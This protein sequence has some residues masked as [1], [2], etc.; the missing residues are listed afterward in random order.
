MGAFHQVGKLKRKCQLTRKVKRISKPA[1]AN[2]S[3][4]SVSPLRQR[5]APPLNVSPTSSSKP[6]RTRT[7]RSRGPFVCQP[8]PCALRPVKHQMVRFQDLESLSNENSQA[9]D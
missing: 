4:K 3:I 6:P 1:V 8:R 2:R 9:C 5:T 7:S